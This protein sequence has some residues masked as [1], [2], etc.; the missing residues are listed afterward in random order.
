MTGSRRTK[1]ND[2][3]QV[4]QH[5]ILDDQH[6]AGGQCFWSDFRCHRTDNR[7]ARNTKPK[8]PQPRK[9]DFNDPFCIT[10]DSR[11]A[12]DRGDIC[13]HKYVA[14]RGWLIFLA[15]R[16]DEQRFDPLFH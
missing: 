14:D 7:L 12:P 13:S 1:E 8:S 2:N 10:W 3:E 6:I 4:E 11:N 16:P 5:R 15:E 9:G